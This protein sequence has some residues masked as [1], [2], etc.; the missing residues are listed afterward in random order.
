LTQK[1]TDDLTLNNFTANTLG[2]TAWES[3]GVLKKMGNITLLTGTYFIKITS[4]AAAVY[5]V[6]LNGLIL[7][8]TGNTALTPVLYNEI[9]PL[10]IY[11]IMGC[12][13]YQGI[14]TISKALKNLPFGVYVANGAKVI[15][16]VGKTI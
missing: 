2:C 3:P 8:K 1:A 7:T 6:H 5:G 11:N 9:Q 12:L 13:V 15:N 16:F 14:N 10:K 4:T